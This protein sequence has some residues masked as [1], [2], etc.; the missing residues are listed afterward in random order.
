MPEIPPIAPLAGTS[1]IA[2]KTKDVLTRVRIFLS[3]LQ[4]G[5]MMVMD[6]GQDGSSE[7]RTPDDPLMD[8]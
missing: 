8:M 3:L 1:R 6:A 4:Q 5:S 2:V 7:T